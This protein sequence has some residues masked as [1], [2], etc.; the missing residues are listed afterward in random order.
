MARFV[1]LAVLW[2]ALRPTSLIR[3]ATSALAHRLGSGH[4]NRK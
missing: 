1:T 4:Q 2:V 3:V